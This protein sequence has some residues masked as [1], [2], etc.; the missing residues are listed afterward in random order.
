MAVKKKYD[1]SGVEPTDYDTPVP[2]GLYQGKITEAERG[3]SK[4]SGRD[5]IALTIEVVNSDGWDG[6]NLWD[7]IGLDEASEWKF[8]QFVSAI[9]APPKGDIDKLVKAALGQRIQV[10]VKHQTDS[11]FGTRARVASL[12]P[13]PEGVGVEDVDDDDEP[14]EPDDDGADDGDEWTMEDV[15]AL[16]RDEMEE[17]IEDEDLDVT[18]NKR[19][20]DDVLRERVAEALGVED[21]DDAAEPD[22][23]EGDED[24]SSMD[25]AALK[26]TAK[27]RGLSAAGSQKTLIKRLEKDDAADD[28]DEPF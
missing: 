3:P 13:M 14:A 23:G 11:E 28:D 15:E 19:T 8:A 27:E 9:E 1:V 25:L 22:D 6:R 24:Y 5:Q 7:Y 21:D 20:K 16:D 2:V 4:S 12:L 26:A 18:F 17:L 10:R